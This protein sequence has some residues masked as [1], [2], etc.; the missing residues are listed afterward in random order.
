VFFDDLLIVVVWAVFYAYWLISAYLTRSPVK[1][2]QSRWTFL[3]YGVIWVVLPIVLLDIF[4]PGLESLRVLP[5]DPVF[6]VIGLVITLTGLAFAIWARVHLGKNWSGLPTIRQDHT[7]VRTGPYRYVRHPIYSGLT[8]ALV[9]TAIGI[10][11]LAIFF[12]VILVFVL[13]LIKSHLEEQFLL[14]EFGEQY[15][16]YKREV[17]SIIP[18]VI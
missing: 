17:K 14:E 15:E 8:L 4:A 12:G 10:G 5:D 2:R 6:F 16:Q 18:F 9:G 7:L 3:S 1:R 13:F 11:Y